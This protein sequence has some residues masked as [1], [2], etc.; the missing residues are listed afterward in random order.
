MESLT[1]F[2]S[3]M[4]LP[5]VLSAAAVWIASAVIW[6]ALPHH[7]N[8]QKGLP[9]EGAFKRFMQGANIPPGNYAFPHAK[10]R[11]ACKSAEFQ[12]AFK[13]G[14]M[15]MLNV[16]QPGKGMGGNMIAT[17][18]VYLVVSLLIAYLGFNSLPPGTPREKLYQVLGTAG[19]LAYCFAFIPNG[20]WFQVSRRAM[21]MNVIDGVVYGLVTA[22]VFAW[23]WP[24]A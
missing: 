11:A 7:Q 23:L 16:W 22:T 12:E 15:G 9:D 18:I 6:M 10:D 13:N 3:V 14:P 2:F 24:A 19:I 20:I 5:I 8:D 1:Q 17:F 4:W 21:F